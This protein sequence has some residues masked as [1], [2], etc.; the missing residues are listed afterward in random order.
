LG[1]D[2]PDVLEAIG[3]IGS[4]GQNHA[5]RRIARRARKNAK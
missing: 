4:E 5:N 3:D 1:S 2:G